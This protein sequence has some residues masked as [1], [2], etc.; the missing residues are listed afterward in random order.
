MQNEV[1]T[2]ELTNPDLV[3][4]VF[5]D[6]FLKPK[7]LPLSRSQDH[8]IHLNHGTINVKPY[9]YPYFE[10]KLWNSWLL[11]CLK[12]GLSGLAGAHSLL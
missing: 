4:I 7:G 8:V 3:P 12:T 2:E 10:N 5:S 1:T 11:T 9:H 6:V